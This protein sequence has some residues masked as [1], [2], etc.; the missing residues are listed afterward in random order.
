MTIICG[1]RDS[2]SIAV[3]PNDRVTLWNTLQNEQSKRS[4][5]NHPTSELRNFM[6]T[7]FMAHA[8]LEDFENL[9]LMAWWKE[10]EGQYLILADMARDLLVNVI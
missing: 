6:A 1:I 4:R 2:K 7:Y 9:D 3:Q 10:K 8:N 5:T